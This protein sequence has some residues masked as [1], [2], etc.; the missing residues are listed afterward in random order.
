MPPDA[1][2]ADAIPQ[3]DKPSGR[4]SGT[5]VKCRADLTVRIKKD[6]R[7]NKPAATLNRTET[8]DY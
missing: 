5:P 6:V 8:H 2:H 1:P 3:R 4:R 7:G